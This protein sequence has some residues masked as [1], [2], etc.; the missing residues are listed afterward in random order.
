MGRAPAPLTRRPVQVKAAKADRA[1]ESRLRRLA[2]QGFA[3]WKQLC[4]PRPGAVKCPYRFP[5]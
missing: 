1:L 5:Q 3:A 2:D 4:P